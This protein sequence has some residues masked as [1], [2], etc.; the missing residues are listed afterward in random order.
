M[1]F[2]ESV[3]HVREVAN[4][5]TGDLSQF[6]DIGFPSSGFD[7]HTC[8]RTPSRQHAHL[9]GRIFL[10]HLV[11]LQAV[12]R[13]V[14]RTNELYVVVLHQSAR[15]ELRVVGDEV[16][17][18]VIDSTCG[19][20]IQ[21]L[22]DTESCLELQMGPVVK[23][24]AESIRN[25]LCPFLELLPV[26]SVFACA[27]TLVHSVG[28]H[29]APFVVVAHEP[30]LCDGFE[31]FVLGNHLRNKVAVIIDNRHFSRMIVIQLLCGLC[32]QQEIFVHERLH[33]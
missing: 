20:G 13:I 22:L 33:N 23:R 15:T 2:L 14:G 9:C 8:V 3:H 4:L 12:C 26:G 17:A 32:L 25:G 27:E 1:A 10:H 24:V 30:D 6:L 16:V 5:H 31:T 18:L 21:T 11:P 28:T 19:L 7:V 29:C